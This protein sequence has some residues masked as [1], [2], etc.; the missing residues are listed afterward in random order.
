MKAFIL[1]A[2]R[3]ERLKPLTDTTPKPLIKV[4]QHRLIEYHLYNLAAA[5]IE[6]VIINI[7]WLGKQIQETL[8]DGEK[9]KLNISYSDEGEEVLETA[10][11]IINALAMLGNDPFIVINGDI[12]SD[13]DLRRLINKE[14]TSEVHLVLV[15]NPDNHPQG[16]FGLDNGMVCNEAAVMYTYS[17]IGIYT[18]SFFDGLKT[19]KLSLSPIL[20]SKIQK[21]LVSGE[22]Y[23]G[24]WTDAGRIERLE[25]LAEQLNC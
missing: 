23:D 8:G 15:D 10:G 1:A 11:G 7:S 16:D 21:Q 17:G 2:G 22:Y 18:A 20:R 13:F 4:G 24:K 6:D 14:I 12:W 5:G 3:G 19:E 9:Y 25:K